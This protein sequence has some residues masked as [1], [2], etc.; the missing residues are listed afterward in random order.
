MP[1]PAG[2]AGFPLD[3][4][5]YQ[6]VKGMVTPLE[7]VADD[8][9]LI[10]A[11]ECAEG[12]GS[13]DYRAAQRRLIDDGAGRFLDLL[14]ARRFADIDEWETEMQL[15]AQ[16]AAQV[17]LFSGMNAADRTLAGVAPIDSVADAVREN[18]AST[19]DQSVAVIPEGPY[20]V[21]VYAGA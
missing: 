3:Q 8:A 16:R 12:L 1:R 11:A 2:P 19:G 7:I 9:T 6:T 21:P 10:V 13:D 18:V 14:L 4:T 17:R 5:Y 20:V 15:R